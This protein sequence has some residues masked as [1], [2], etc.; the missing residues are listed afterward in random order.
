M[1]FNDKIY[2]SKSWLYAYVDPKIVL[3]HSY[4]ILKLVNSTPPQSTIG[5]VNWGGVLLIGQ[6]ML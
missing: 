4:Q 1:K 3:P 5:I 6:I 2:L